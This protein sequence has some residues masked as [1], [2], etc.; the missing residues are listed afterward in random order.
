MAKYLIILIIFTISF[1]YVYDSTGVEMRDGI[2]LGTDIYY[3]VT[4]FPPWPTLLQRTPYGRDW[5][6][7]Y[8]FLFTD[9]LGYVFV[10]QNVRGYGDSQGEPMVFLTDG[11]GAL[12]DGYD[13]V[14]WIADHWWSNGKIGMLGGSA[15]GITQYYAAGALPPHLVC[16]A[17]MVAAPSLYHH[18]G[19]T[20]GEFRKALVE[21]WLEGVET[22]WLIDTV[23]NHPNYDTMWSVVDLTTRWDV[24]DYPMFHID[25]WYDMYTDG[26]LETFS[27][28]QARYHNQKLFIGPWGHGDAW[29]T[30]EQGDLVYPEN[31][32]M[33]EL[34]FIQLIL[35]WYNYWLQDSSGGILEPRVKFYLMGDCDTQDTT[36][37]NH[38]VEA[39]TWPLPEVVYKKYYLRENGLLD[40]IPPQIAEIDTFIYDPADPCTTYGGREFI[41]LE[42]GYGPINQN[43]IEG[44][45]DVLVFSTEP[46]ASPLTVI[47]KLWFVLYAASDCYD[48]DWSVRVTDVY[49]DGRSILVTDNILMARH[50][51]GFDR[52][53]SL[54]PNVPDTFYIDL[55]STAQVFNAGHRLRVIIS[56][57]N[58]PRFEKNPNT[59]APFKR[60]DSVFVVATQKVYRTPTM[61]SYLF[62]PVLPESNPYVEE[63]AVQERQIL[64]SEVLMNT[65]CRIPEL[66]LNLKRPTELNL[67]LYN[68][69]GQMVWSYMNQD[70]GPGKKRIRIPE[71]AAGVYFLNCKLGERKETVKLV[72]IK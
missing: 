42:N 68:I 16:C 41:G 35:N 46:L 44:R 33:D 4:S 36:L 23:C 11:W 6:S 48:T 60:D 71:M 52:E 20:G 18:C 37:W 64:G 57:S 72:I 8:I 62:L 3:P 59:G 12:Q 45:S 50:R 24:A 34:E 26:V 17:P 2:K 40:T 1:G 51:H 27:E 15:H 31:A 28:L 54:I 66:S 14:E 19:F 56:S 5:D 21:N 30:R 55:W 38:W 63:R 61:A 58:Y 29:G 10:V 9:V 47:G 22:P 25:G 65:I 32:E 53:D 49:P 7:T 69:A 67:S 43:P 13:A 70:I 39:D